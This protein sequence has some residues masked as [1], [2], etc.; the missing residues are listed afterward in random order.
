MRTNLDFVTLTLL[1]STL[2]KRLPSAHPRGQALHLSTLGT[3]TFKGGI[4]AKPIFAPI[5]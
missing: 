1:L 5:E 4:S 2:G 3:R